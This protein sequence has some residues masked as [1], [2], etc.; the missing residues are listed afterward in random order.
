[1][2][3]D[4][5]NTKFGYFIIVRWS[6]VRPSMYQSAKFRTTP[7][8]LFFFYQIEQVDQNAVDIARKSD[9]DLNNILSVGNIVHIRQSRKINFLEP[10]EF[11]KHSLICCSMF[12]LRTSKQNT[13][14]HELLI[15]RSHN[16]I[17][18][19]TFIRADFFMLIIYYLPGDPD[20]SGTATKT[21]RTHSRHQLQGRQHMYTMF[22]QIQNLQRLHHLTS[23][24]FLWVSWFSGVFL[25]S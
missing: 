14:L 16:S 12:F 2:N 9:P 8:V 15:S 6:K 25:C 20:D 23:L 4:L 24:A 7:S 1:M 19:S 13:C 17:L 5:T 21:A 22:T 3:L 18:H 11:L 10:V